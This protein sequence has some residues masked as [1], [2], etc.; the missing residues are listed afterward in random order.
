[1]TTSDGREGSEPAGLV[2]RGVAAVL[3][4]FTLALAGLVIHLAVGCAVLLVTGP[5]FR[6]PDLPGPLAGAVSWI[7]AVVYLAG[8]WTALG[9]TPG[10]RLMG[11]HVTDRAGHALTLPRSLLRAALC[12]TFPLGLCWVP[13]SRRR[14]SL[15]DLVVAGAVVYERR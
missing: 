1:M 10:G 15:Q 12:V 11:L 6:M 14:A 3:D 8:C 4:A 5:P 13:L 9:C 2:S 7:A